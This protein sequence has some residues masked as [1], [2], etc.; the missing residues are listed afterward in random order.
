MPLKGGPGQPRQRG[1]GAKGPPE[2]SASF[3]YLGRVLIDARMCVQGLFNL[4][5]YELLDSFRCLKATG[6]LLIEGGW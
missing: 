6:I 5:F 1:S 2:Q 3:V 4:L